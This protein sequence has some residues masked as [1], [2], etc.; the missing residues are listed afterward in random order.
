VIEINQQRADAP[1]AVEGYVEIGTLLLV[2]HIPCPFTSRPRS[3]IWAS[4]Y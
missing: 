1:V 3:A 2:V 4:S